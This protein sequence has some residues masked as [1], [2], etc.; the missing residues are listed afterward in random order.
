MSTEQV[1]DE[2]GNVTILEDGVNPLTGTGTIVNT[3]V[4]AHFQLMDLL[5]GKFPL[6]PEMKLSPLTL[7]DL[8]E[9]EKHFGDINTIEEA[10]GSSMLK[11][12]TLLWILCKREQPDITPEEVGALIN[13]DNMESLNS[14][15]QKIMQPAGNSLSANTP[16]M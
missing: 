12:R 5:Q 13:V 1:K 8:A 2:Q 15:I 4:K 9:L 3:S 14:A 7:N 16:E 6:T 10:I 11:M